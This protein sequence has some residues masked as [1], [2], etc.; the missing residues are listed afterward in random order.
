MT[1]IT[2]GE[3][4]ALSKGGKCLS[5]S[6][7][8]LE[9]LLRM[10][11]ESWGSVTKYW[12]LKVTK[13]NAFRYLDDIRRAGLLNIAAKTGATALTNGRTVLS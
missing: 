4:K 12:G 1:K 11:K 5:F 3:Q 10:C 9:I 2:Y 13:E 8:R 6:R 7:R